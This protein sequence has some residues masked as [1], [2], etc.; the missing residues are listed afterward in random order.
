VSCSV[1]QCRRAPSFTR[2]IANLESSHVRRVCVL[3]CVAVCCS[4]LQCVAV[5]VGT[6]ITPQNA[7]HQT[8]HVRCVCVCDVL[9]CVLQC[10]AVCCRVQGVTVCCSVLQCVAVCCSVLQCVAVCCSVSGHSHHSAV[11]ES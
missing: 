6:L 1:L 8:S 3:Q 5:S 2:Q 11:C 7:S 4:V 9:W 10:I